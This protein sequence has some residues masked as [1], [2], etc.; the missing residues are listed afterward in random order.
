MTPILFDLD[1]TLIDVSARHYFLYRSVISG[2]GVEALPEGDFWR[3]RRAG[4]STIDLLAATL[5]VDVERFTAA[6]MEGIERPDW[7]A[8]DEPYEGVVEILET[9]GREYELVLIT[10]RRDRGALMD[11][12][13]A[14]HMRSYFT[15]VICHGPRLVSG[16]HLLQ[17]VAELTPGGYAVGDT[18]ADIELASETG[19][20]AICLS[21]GV[22]S[23]RYLASRGAE[24]V[25]GSL[26]E[27]PEVINAAERSGGP[28]DVADVE[29]DLALRNVHTRARF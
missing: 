23:G 29:Q 4:E 22:R 17:G 2:Q 14:L 9:L 11:Q 25:I 6:W 16:K 7:L 24:T 10:L 28:A 1:G 20:R 19:R 13:D 18:E 15:E 27:L 8:R 21:Y 12:L 5:G 26:R 3:H